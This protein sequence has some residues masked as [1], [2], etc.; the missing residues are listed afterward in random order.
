MTPSFIIVVGTY[1]FAPFL[2]RCLQSLVSQTLQPDK[3]I[4]CDD[5]SNDNSW[6]IMESLQN[7]YRNLIEIHKT[8]R[9]LG[10]IGNGDYLYSLLH[11]KIFEFIS[12]IDGDDYWDPR[13][14]ELEYAA[15]KACPY[16]E[17]AFSDVA[18]TDKK[19]NSIGFWKK[20]KEIPTNGDLFSF[21]LGRNYFSKTHSIFRNELI[22]WRA[23][24]EEGHVNK[25]LLNFWDWERKIRLSDKYKGA[26][27]GE[28]LVYYRQHPGGISKTFGQD[29][30]LAAMIDVYEKHLP[31]LSSRSHFEQL[32]VRISFES[33]AARQRKQ[34]SLSGY[35]QYSHANVAQRIAKLFKKV[36]QEEKKEI[37]GIFTKELQ[38]IALGNQPASPRSMAPVA[39][40]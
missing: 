14:L 5:C 23:H 12:H 18:L 8:P 40:P 9:R 31:S 15:I 11:N 36:D 29:N 38:E 3:I 34:L 4:I 2:E 6:E 35:D 13:K 26:H 22:S 16:A 37:T 32:F 33:L 10:A 17:F 7:T 28:T 21:V 20:Q 27:S 19:D 30:L 25:K 1:Q 39:A 24:Q